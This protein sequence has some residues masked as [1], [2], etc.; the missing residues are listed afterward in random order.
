MDGWCARRALSRGAIMTL[1]QCW[2]MAQGWYAGRLE[3]GWRGRSPA[4]A[5]AILEAAGLNGPFWRMV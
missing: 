4:A 1:D 2:S 5:Q 3:P